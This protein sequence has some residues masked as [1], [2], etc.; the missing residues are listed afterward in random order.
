[1]IDC[2]MNPRF[3]TRDEIIA[4][5]ENSDDVWAVELARRS[6]DD[7]DE[8]RREI[9]EF[10][11]E[12]NVVQNEADDLRNDLRDANDTISSLRYD[13]DANVRAQEVRRLK[14]TL[15]KVRRQHKHEITTL[16][17]NLKDVNQQ[18]DLVTSKF[19]TWSILA[20]T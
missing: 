19:N 4:H 5:C 12:L 11:S 17:H 1:M 8:L 16:T 18:L 10:E 7:I 20:A 9:G 15:H 14:A 2:K 6:D 3:A 13:D